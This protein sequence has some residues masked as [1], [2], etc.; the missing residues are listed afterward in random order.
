MCRTVTDQ[1]MLAAALTGIRCAGYETKPARKA[2]KD[3]SKF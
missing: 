1:R 3:Y 2:I